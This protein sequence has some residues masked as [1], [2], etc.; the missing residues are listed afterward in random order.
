MI[1]VL[2]ADVIGRVG[3]DEVDGIFGPG[4]HAF[5]AIADSDGIERKRGIWGGGW[6]GG[7]VA[8]GRA[9]RE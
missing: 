5:D 3:K 7:I 8:K 1:V 6:H 2:V 4:P 9:E